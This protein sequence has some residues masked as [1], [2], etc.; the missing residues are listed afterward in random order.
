MIKEFESHKDFLKFIKSKVYRKVGFGSEGSCYWGKDGLAYKV[1]EYF[2][3]KRNV[4]EI[5]T[6]DKY[7][8]LN[9]FALPID[10]YTNPDHSIIYGY[11]SNFL[12]DDILQ[13]SEDF[14]E[15]VDLD[16]LVKCYYMLL[17]DIRTISNDNIF[18][19]EL[20][21]NLL[22]NNI[23]FMLID[24][25]DYYKE[26]YNTYDDNVNMI[27]RAIELPLYVETNDQA[28]NDEKSIEEI[29]ENVK[30]Y[31]KKRKYY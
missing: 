18:L 27:L 29:A 26:D 11:N 8:D 31:V 6:S 14:F 30:K 3:Y 24:T 10:I 19:F 22:F 7:K 1:I 9:Y 17:S 5:I 13:H 16:K 23:K 2:L 21:N 20:I 4:N 25:L 28:F 12:H 15:E